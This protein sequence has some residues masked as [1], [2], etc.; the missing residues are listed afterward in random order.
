MAEYTSDYNF[1]ID[2][3]SS[4]AYGVF[5]ATLEPVPPAKQRYTSGYTGSPEPYSIPD[6]V[7]EPISYSITF[8]KFYPDSMDDSA[9][10]LF[11]SK[12]SAL[13]LSNYPL[14]YFKILTISHTTRQTADNKRI[15]YTVRFTLKPFKYG[16]NNPWS[17]LTSGDIL[18]NGG[19][20]KSNPLIELTNPDGDITF[21]VNEVEYK[22]YSLT[23]GTAE[24]PKIYYIDSERFC[25]YRSDYELITGKDEGKLP[26]LLVGANAISWTGTVETVRIRT[27]WR[28]I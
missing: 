24:S 1:S 14:V 11:L 23:V 15:E 19:T 7:F 5:V 3:V 27:N 28:E 10:R 17:T 6:N 12:G 21:T 4:D 18:T 26:E 22:V 13:Q 16:L 8:Y 20:W 9:I 25:I 2:G